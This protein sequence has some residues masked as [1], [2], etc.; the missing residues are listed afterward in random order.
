MDNVTVFPS[1]ASPLSATV[2]TISASGQLIVAGPQNV[3]PNTFL[4]DD[5][6]DVVSMSNSTAVVCLSDAKLQEELRCIALKF[7]SPS[8]IVIVS[9]LPLNGFGA[10]VAFQFL[11]IQRLSEYHFAVLANNGRFA[12]TVCALHAH[13]LSQ[14]SSV[15]EL[16]PSVNN[17]NNNS[18]WIATTAVNRTRFAILYSFAPSDTTSVVLGSLLPPAIGF[19]ASSN[20]IVS[21]GLIEPSS[22]ANQIVP[23]LEYYCDAQGNLVA[24]RFYGNTA[25]IP[26]APLIQT[27]GNILMQKIGVGVTLKQI[28]LKI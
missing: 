8:K 1:V 14:S 4:I 2:A 17:W 3:F 5:F 25:N 6:F 21:S 10:D 11:Y 24:G 9:S 15:L 26:H 12:F 19:A 28:L 7:Y 23:G 20:R 16:S 22:L 13:I 27:N 18:W